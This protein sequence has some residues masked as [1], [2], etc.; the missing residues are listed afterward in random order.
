MHMLSDVEHA[1]NGGWLAHKK[2]M[3]RS[4]VESQRNHFF[5]TRKLMSLVRSPL[6]STM[7]LL[8]PGLLTSQTSQRPQLVLSKDFSKLDAY[9]ITPT[10]KKVRAHSEEAPCKSRPQSLSISDSNFSVPKVMDDTIP[11]HIKRKVSA[12]GSNKKMKTSENKDVWVFTAARL[13]WEP[14]ALHHDF[15]G[16]PIGMVHLITLFDSKFI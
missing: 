7:M 10:G 12:W 5:A 8:E 16:N 6:I 2:S 15:L 9:Y 3:R 11:A 4:E 13:Y 14:P 1:S